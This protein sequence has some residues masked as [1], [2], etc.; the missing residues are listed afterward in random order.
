MYGRPSNYECMEGHQILKYIKLILIIINLL[1]IH[2]NRQGHSQ[3]TMERDRDPVYVYRA[4]QSFH[5]IISIVVIV[6]NVIVLI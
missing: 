5:H 1:I 6:I 4:H 2:M 3:P